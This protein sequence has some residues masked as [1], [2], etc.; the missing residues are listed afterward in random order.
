MKRQFINNVYSWIRNTFGKPEDVDSDRSIRS[1]RFIEEAI[2]L[3]QA[4]GTPKEEVAT[5]LEYVYSR[6][7]G[8]IQQEVGGV[9][10]T[11]AGHASIFGYDPETCGNTELNRIRKID[12]NKILLKD[13][14]KPKF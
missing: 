8:E 7:K 1:R 3:V 5:I 4:C 13:L 12:P 14:A 11:L 2:E 6:P 9:M 10:V